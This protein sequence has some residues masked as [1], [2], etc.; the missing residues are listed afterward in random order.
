MSN[1]KWITLK[2]SSLKQYKFIIW[3]F[4]QVWNSGMGT[5]RW[6]CLYLLMRLPSTSQPEPQLSEGWTGAGRT[7]F[8]GDSVTQPVSWSS[9][10]HGP[11][12][13]LRVSFPVVA[14]FPHSEQFWRAN[15][16]HGA[17]DVTFCQS[18]RVLF[19]W[20][21]SGIQGRELGCFMSFHLFFWLHREAYGIL[22]PRAE[23]EPVSHRG[24]S[25]KS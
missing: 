24:E 7:H 14:D 9:S 13:D 6:F 1:A 23:I 12:C 15:T 22:V 5:C 17:S 10:P 20:N 19:I 2:L 4:L 3:R 11:L 25:M 18:Y 8:S 21:E 16:S